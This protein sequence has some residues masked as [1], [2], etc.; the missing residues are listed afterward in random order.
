MSIVL[1]VAGTI[2]NSFVL[3]IFWKSPKLRSKL[4]SFGIMLL[5]SIDLGVVTVI[6]PLFVLK[7]ITILDSPKCLYIVAYKIAIFFFCGISACTL[8]IINIER[9][10]A[11]IHPF[12]YR[13]HFNKRRFVFTWLFFWFLVVVGIVSRVIIVS[14]SDCLGILRQLVRMRSQS[15]DSCAKELVSLRKQYVKKV[16]E[17]KKSSEARFICLLMRVLEYANVKCPRA[18]SCGL[19]NAAQYGMYFNVMHILIYTYLIRGGSRIKSDRCSPIRWSGVRCRRT[20]SRGVRVKFSPPGKFLKIKI[21]KRHFLQISE[22]SRVFLD[23]RF[24][25]I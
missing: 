3:F 8:L 5:Y 13:I 16:L 21:L 4:F 7:S 2:S 18:R 20:P 24:V 9:Y 15:D 6:N 10:F 17:E 22:R 14:H 12:L 11:I 25:D 1:A 23:G 19:L